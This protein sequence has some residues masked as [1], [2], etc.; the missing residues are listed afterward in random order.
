MAS[1]TST[2]RAIRA[3][4]RAALATPRPSMPIPQHRSFA[5]ISSHVHF[6]ILAPAPPAPSHSPVTRRYVSSSGHA[7]AD[8]IANRLQQMY[9]EARDEFEIAVESTEAHAVYAQSDRDATREELEK[10]KRAWQE[11]LFGPAEVVEDLK[12]RPIAQRIRELENALEGLEKRGSA[13]L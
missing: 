10:L 12:K 5:S 7:A 6:P 13:G 3:A 2:T 1:K 8:K 4:S 11:A 9:A